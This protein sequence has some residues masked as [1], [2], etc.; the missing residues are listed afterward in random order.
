MGLID[1]TRTERVNHPWEENEW[2]DIRFLT[3][4]EMDEAQETRIKRLLDLWGNTL[5]RQAGNGEAPTPQPET[6]A[7]RLQKYDPRILLE[8]AI[9]NWS[10]HD[11]VTPESISRLDQAT[12]EWLLEE[13]V[14]RNTRPLD[15]ATNG[16]AP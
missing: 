1:I 8:R 14:K 13:V 4:P 10:Y 2:C 9:V 11:N 5:T 7:T 15:S 16:A 12:R 6:M 3:G